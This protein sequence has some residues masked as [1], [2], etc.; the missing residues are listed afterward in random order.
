MERIV[1]MLSS[2]ISLLP[3]I[4]PLN[5]LEII[6]IALVIYALLQWLWGTRGRRLLRGLLVIFIFMV[7]CVLLRLDTLLWIISKVA[8]IAAVALLVI[9]QPELR[10]ALER[11]GSR[12]IWDKAF[13]FVL[14]K[15]KNTLD[16]RTVNEI[17][18]AVFEMS[19]AKTGALIVLEREESLK[20][21]ERTGI[22]LRADI[23]SQLLINIFEHNTPL[24]D[25]AVII[26]DNKISAATCYLP[27]SDNLSISKDLGTRH[28]AAIGISEITDSVTVVVSEETGRV[29][30]ARG[31][32]LTVADTPE[33]LRK[34]L[35]GPAEKEEGARRFRLLR[36][37]RLFSVLREKLSRNVSLIPLSVALAVV[38]WMVVV[39]ISNPLV[40]ASKTVQ[41]EIRNE[42]VITGVGKTFEVIGNQSVSVSYSVRARDQY[43]IRPSDFRAYADLS[44]L[45]DVTGAVPVTLEVVNNRDLLTDTPVARPGFIK[46][47]IENMVRK[48]ISVTAQL[49]GS[50]AGGYELGPVSVN[51]SYVVMNGPQSLLNAVD[52]AAVPVDVSGADE[53]VSGSASLLF[54]NEEDMLVN[55]DDERVTVNRPNAN[56]Y[57]E[58]HGGKTIPVQYSITGTPAPGY[59]DTSVDATVGSVTVRGTNSA[60]TQAD[61][62]VVPLSIEGAASDMVWE[63][64]LSQ[65]LPEGLTIQDSQVSVVTA[66]VEPVVQRSFALSLSQ[67]EQVGQTYGYR[68][69]IEPAAVQVVVSGL[70][71]YVDPLQA[72]QLGAQID[73][74]GLS[75]G[76]RSGSLAF[77]LPE[78]VSLVSYSP[79]MLRIAEPEPEPQPETLELES[80]GESAGE[81]EV[82]TSDPY[83]EHMTDWSDEEEPSE[84]EEEPEEENPEESA[85]ALPTE[86]QPELPEA[87]ETAQEGQ[88]STES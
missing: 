22:P 76:E 3:H 33:Q 72:S 80:T 23:S 44:N 60:L 24:H 86:E 1:E 51:P 78:G 30:V 13:A 18:K 63:V 79:F 59:S 21:I 39:N 43:K 73:L 8:T 88:E 69:S 41:V 38:T 20:E 70:Q 4:Q 83:P 81:G 58:L 55:L 37:N 5:F 45:Y 34:E 7:F 62:I 82:P 10:R 17:V 50:P 6:I 53:N 25:G 16:E 67:I 12:D 77:R 46:I 9:F 2:W 14:D 11:L 52:H 42:G 65:Y 47:E 84:E 85:A 31:G 48:E 54:Y 26:S 74:S 56:Y 15:E 57:V 19:R 49:E 61:S 36:K 68:Y 71:R 28:R 35:S 29:S 87:G 32:R 64:D 27:L 75:P 66:R 40:T